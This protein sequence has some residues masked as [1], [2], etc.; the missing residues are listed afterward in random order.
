MQTKNLKL[1]GLFTLILLLFIATACTEDSLSDP[2]ME[3]MEEE[4]EEMEEEEENTI[5]NAE[6]WTGTDLTFS[7]ANNANPSEESNQD[8][9]TDKV[10]ITRGNNGGQIYNAKTEGSASKSN[11]PDG[12]EWAIGD[13]ADIATLNFRPFR[14]AVSSPKNVEGKDLVLHLIDDNIY[15]KVRFTSWSSS[16]GGG[17]SYVRS[18]K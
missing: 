9:L 6:I 17:F 4:E 8:R 7:K 11:S 2:N 15:L 10:W 5:A 14:S 16:K 1:S 13:I 12:T 3:P 18:T